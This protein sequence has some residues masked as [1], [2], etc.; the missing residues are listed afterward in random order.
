MHKGGKRW[1]TE[2]TMTQCYGGP[3]EGGW[4]YTVYEV[5]KSKKY[6]TARTAHAE[7]QRQFKNWEDYNRYNYDDRRIFCVESWKDLGIEDNSNKPR[8]IY[9]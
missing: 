6:S 2:Y 9:E 5:V 1:V 7:Q 8:P 3:E 4:W